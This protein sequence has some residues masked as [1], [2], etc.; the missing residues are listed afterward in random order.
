MPNFPIKAEDLMKKFNF[1]EGRKLGE[2]LKILENYWIKNNFQI[3]DK[4]L[5]RIIKS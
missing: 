5:R 4:D 3:N 2:S 1:S